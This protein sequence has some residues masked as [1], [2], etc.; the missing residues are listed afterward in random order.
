MR[1]F[2]KVTKVPSMRLWCIAP[3]D[4]PIVA[5][6]AR[7][8]SHKGWT[9]ILRWKWD[10]E[11]RGQHRRRCVDHA[12]FQSHLVRAF[13]RWYVLLLPWLGYVKYFISQ[14]AIPA[15]KNDGTEYYPYELKEISWAYPVNG[16]SLLVATT[17][18]KLRVL[19]FQ[20]DHLSHTLRI[21]SQIY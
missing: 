10:T 12:G 6:I 9:C 1:L 7:C 4:A 18:A 14:T 19:R 11:S 5:D 15:N 8:Y 20:L 3:S 13:S 21:S 2:S 17:D 16:A